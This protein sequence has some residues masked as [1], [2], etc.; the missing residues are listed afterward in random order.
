ML[1]QPSHHPAINRSSRRRPKRHRRGG[2]PTCSGAD[3]LT[4]ITDAKNQ[5]TAWVYDTLNRITSETDPLNK[6]TSYSY[7]ATSLPS[8]RTDANGQTIRAVE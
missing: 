8:S 7:G 2:R 5:K 4:S 3:Q 6:V 1:P